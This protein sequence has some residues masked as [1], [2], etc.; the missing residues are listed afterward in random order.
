MGRSRREADCGGAQP[1][2]LSLRAFCWWS[3]APLCPIVSTVTILPEDEVLDGSAIAE[4]IQEQREEFELAGDSQLEIQ[5][6]AMGFN[7]R[8]RDPKSQA[9]RGSRVAAQQ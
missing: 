8:G 6:L 3:L 2:K 9:D 5:V 7:R 1:G 4:R